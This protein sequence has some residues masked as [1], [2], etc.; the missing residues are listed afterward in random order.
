MRWPKT[1]SGCR[2]PWTPGR[3]L[4]SAGAWFVVALSPAACSSA[5][6]GGGDP[7][8]PDQNGVSG[9]TQVVIELTVSDTA[10]TVGAID[11]GPGEPNI[12]TENSVTV[13]LTMTNVG[14]KPHD[15]AIRCLPTTNSNGCPTQSCFPHGADLPPLKPGAHATAVFV[16]PVHEGPYPFV[17]DV[18]GDTHAGADGSLT[19][20]VGQFVV[21]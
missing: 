3:W 5:A 9:G 11:S 19:G 2:F 6:P 12:T 14:S 8:N 1:A 18:P 21:M 15:F 17:S 10:F 7:C 16:T 4:A 13:S 20:L